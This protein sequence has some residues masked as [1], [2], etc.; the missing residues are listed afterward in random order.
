MIC[1]KGSIISKPK[2]IYNEHMPANAKSWMANYHIT[3]STCAHGLCNQGIFHFREMYLHQS[4]TCTHVCVPHAGPV[5]ARIGI[6]PLEMELQMLGGVML[7]LGTE[8]GSFP[9]HALDG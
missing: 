8:L 1:L 4:F 5:E 2:I 3:V 7:L 6:D 9:R